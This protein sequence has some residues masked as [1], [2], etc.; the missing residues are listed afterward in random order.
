MIPILSILGLGLAAVLDETGHDFMKELGI[1]TRPILTSEDLFQL[2]KKGYT[3]RSTKWEVYVQEFYVGTELPGVFVFGMSHKIPNQAGPVD[4]LAEAVWY[5]YDVHGHED[6]VWSDQIMAPEHPEL[7]HPG[8]WL[9]R[10]HPC[11]SLMK[12]KPHNDL[13]LYLQVTFIQTDAP[14]QPLSQEAI[15]VVNRL[16]GLPR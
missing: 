7:R 6:F 13:E 10:K 11:P 1:W 9:V 12:D 5:L 8:P 2:E 14:D 4:T 16:M 15:E 3:I